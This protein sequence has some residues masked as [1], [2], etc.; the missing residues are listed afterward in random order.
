MSSILL[1][2]NDKVFIDWLSSYLM[3]REYLVTPI[4]DDRFSNEK[5]ME[6]LSEPDLVVIVGRLSSMSCFEL[7]RRFR[8]SFD[9]SILILT[10]S[11]N[12][13]DEIIALEIGADDYLAK[14][15]SERLL[16]TR[17]RALIRR[18]GCSSRVSKARIEDQFTL[19]RLTINRPDRAVFLADRS[20]SLSSYEFDALWVLAKNAG[21]VVSRDFMFRQ[22]R[23]FEYDGFDRSIDLR[24]SRIRK[25]LSDDTQKPYKIK[26]IW[27]KGYL[28]AKDVWN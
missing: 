17:I 22:L 8:K 9:C 12:E 18:S 24:I 11:R 16:E 3:Q 15:V 4:Y 26:T 19:G 21:E 13:V 2:G 6:S 27:G 1:V 5:L 10:D 14:P 25:K 20:I 7:C 28:L 23:G